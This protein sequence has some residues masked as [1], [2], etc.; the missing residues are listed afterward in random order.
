M[1][2]KKEASKM[3]NVSDLV[4][5]CV[6]RRKNATDGVQEK[7]HKRL[8]Y[9]RHARARPSVRI[10][11]IFT[12]PNISVLHFFPFSNSLSLAICV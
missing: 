8:L 1:A 3:E 6:N 10:V 12:A 4:R 2:Y 7:T 11:D 9:A 5:I